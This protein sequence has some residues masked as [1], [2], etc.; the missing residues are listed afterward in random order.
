MTTMVP[1]SLALVKIEGD[2]KA[3]DD[4]DIDAIT[5]KKPLNA[6]LDRNIAPP[7]FF[8]NLNS[9]SPLSTDHITLFRTPTNSFSKQT[10]WG[11]QNF[12]IL[13]NNPKSLT[14]IRT[15]VVVGACLRSIKTLAVSVKTFFLL[16][17][18]NAIAK[19]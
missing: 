19:K 16:L 11:T 2:A 10:N 4:A 15:V 9:S 7:S 12:P 14:S 3:N 5:P 18:E 13:I 17:L 1:I 8:A 6:R